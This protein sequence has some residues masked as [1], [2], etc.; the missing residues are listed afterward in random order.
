MRRATY[1]G[2]TGS[3]GYL[4]FYPRSPCGERPINTHCQHKRQ[5]ISIHALLAESDSALWLSPDKGHPFLST[6]SLRRATIRAYQRYFPLDISIHALLAESDG[7]GLVFLWWGVRFLSTLS[8]RRA[9][10]HYDNYNLHCTISIHA[11]LA[12]S[13]QRTWLSALHNSDFYP[14]SPCGERQANSRAERQEQH[15]SIH[16]LLAESDTPSVFLHCTTYLF[17]STLSLR[18][19]T[20]IVPAPAI[21]IPISIHALLAE[22]DCILTISICTA[23]KFLSTLSL[24]RATHHEKKKSTRQAISIHA[25]LAESD[26]Q[27]PE[28]TT[29]TT[30]FYPRSPC[31]ERRTQSASLS[32]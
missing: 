9:T 27:Q 25:L 18:R 21:V 12:E 19:A 6:L 11:L 1:Q 31:G 26:S 23:L 32:A 29:R 13:D 15:I 20:I 28:G 10:V 4:H 30:Y 5:Q 7:I 17:L 24:R 14:R 3:A 8:L 2:Q 22:S 16:A